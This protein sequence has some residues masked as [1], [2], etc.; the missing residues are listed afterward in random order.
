MNQKAADFSDVLLNHDLHDPPKMMGC[1]VIAALTATSFLPCFSVCLLD[2]QFGEVTLSLKS[3]LTSDSSLQSPAI[4]RCWPGNLSKSEF[5]KPG[6]SQRRSM[7]KHKH[8][9]S[10][11]DE[12]QRVQM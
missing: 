3:S 7:Q 11:A 12:H 6:R 4:A 9:F 8:K 10:V 5:P 2:T 1:V